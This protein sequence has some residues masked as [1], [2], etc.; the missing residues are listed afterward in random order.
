M[1]VL[2][3]VA[4]RILQGIPLVLGVSAVTFFLIFA[5]P[6]NYVSNLRAANPNMSDREFVLLQQRLGITPDARWYETWAKWV[7]GIITRG[8]LGTSFRNGRPVNRILGDAMGATA[9][10]GFASMAIAWTIAI[11]LGMLAAIRRNTFMDY[12]ASG[13]AFLGLSVPPIVL[14]ALALMLADS[15]GWFPPGDM[16][17]KDHH[18][19]RTRWDRWMDI[20]HHLI[21]PALVLAAG[22]MA[23]LT[24]Q[25][26]S[27]LL[28]TLEADF[29]RTARAK[30]ISFTWAVLG[31]AF[32]NAINPLITILGFSIAGLLSGAFL[33]E[34][35]MNWPGLGRI[36]YD[37]YQA[38]D[39][40]VVA[41]GVVMGTVMLL[42]GNLISDIL[43][44]ANDPRIRMN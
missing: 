13:I 37:A 43:L 41:V 15:T 14:A 8:E 29:V 27:N 16:T 22:S 28:E 12:G 30:G 21:L 4:M 5:S 1:I 9:L 20:G 39:M 26:R 31:H 40:Y 25:M 35:I 17:S 33:V 2:R 11:P 34:A 19:L 24:R 3:L 42:I 23:S 38:K 10:L 6:G 18:L 7:G 44:M 32:R 36:I